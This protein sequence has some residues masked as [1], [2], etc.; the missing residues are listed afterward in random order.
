MKRNILYIL[1]AVGMCFGFA[2][3]VPEDIK[4][5]TDIARHQIENLKCEVDDE[6][7]T[8]SWSVPE[9]WEPTDYL[10]TYNDA[11]QIGRAHV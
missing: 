7:V 6:E 1:A 5:D 10:I 11:A 8:L 2:S 9:G 3:C 4:N